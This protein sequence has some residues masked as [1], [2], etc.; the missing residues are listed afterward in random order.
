MDLATGRIVRRPCFFSLQPRRGS[1][2]FP[3]RAPCPSIRRREAPGAQLFKAVNRRD[4]DRILK[5]ALGKFLA[6]ETDRYISH[7]FRRGAD[8][9][10]KEFGSP[11][12]V[13][14]P[15]GVRRSPAFRGYLDMS[16]DV[17]IGIRQL[18]EVDLDSESEAAHA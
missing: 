14:A 11:R 16:R 3:V 10:L 4:F 9:E 8:Q 17:E 12:S 1:L 15:E 2:L 18:F 6:P 7:A 13:V 5:T